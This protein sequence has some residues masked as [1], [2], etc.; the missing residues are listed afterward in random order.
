M[1]GTFTNI[2]MHIVFSTKD[3][4]PWIDETGRRRAFDYLG[5][6]IKAENAVLYEINGTADHVH[7]LVRMRP[8]VSVSDFL[9]NLKS[10]SS[11]WI[12]RT[13][14]ALKEFHWQDGYGAFSVSR[15]QTEKV[16][17]YIADQ[18]GHHKKEDFKTEFLKIQKAN[19]LSY[20]ERYIWK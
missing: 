16:K 11:G 15:S 4:R 8:D 18:R 7:L 13:F 3:H 5:G 1:A 6:I 14:P 12:R 17:R 20:D 2:L 19:N 9:R 10:K